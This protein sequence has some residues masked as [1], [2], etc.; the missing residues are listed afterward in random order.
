MLSVITPCYN[1]GVFLRE[2][3]ENILDLEYIEII[4]VDDGSKDDDTLA[5]LN[6]LSAKG[7]KIIHQENAG[8]AA[9][10]NRGVLESTGDYLLFLDSDNLIKPEYISKAIQLFEADDKIGVVYAKPIFF[11]DVDS[12]EER[13]QVQRFNF[14]RLLIGNYIDMCSFVR[15]K[16]WQSTKG[17]DAD[18]KGCEDWD[19]WIQLAKNGW[20]FHFID[21]ELFHY[22]VVGGSVSTFVQGGARENILNQIS[23]RHHPVIYQRYKYYARL[24]RKI[25]QRPFL[26]FLKIVY[27]KYILGKDY[28]PD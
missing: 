23:S 12:E 25:Q 26:F 1:S 8:P 15:R 28:L 24:Y 4:V 2:A 20:K 27:S 14:D 18:N 22:R 17:F 7:V 16:A 3:L 13:F 10:R 5:Y 9:A 11:G 6:T 19:L 21:E